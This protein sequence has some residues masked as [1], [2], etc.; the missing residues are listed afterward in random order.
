MF[1]PLPEMLVGK[2]DG[3]QREYIEPIPHFGAL[4][5]TVRYVYAG[6]KNANDQISYTVQTKY[7]LPKDDM[8]VL[9]RITKGNI[10]S[11]KATGLITFDNLAGHVLQH[12]RR[13][14]LRG[15]LTIEAM[16]RKQSMEFTSDNEVKVRIKSTKR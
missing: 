8:S 4:R 12:D 9:F 16:E 2:G 13:M 7:E 11:E 15:S 3:W 14:L 1:G 6:T 10:T 5:A